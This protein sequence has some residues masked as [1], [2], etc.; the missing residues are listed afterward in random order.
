MRYRVPMPRKPAV[1]M[2]DD[3]ALSSMPDGPRNAVRYS[4][5]FAEDAHAKLGKEAIVFA[6]ERLS[7]TIIYENEAQI[8]R[9]VES[10]LFDREWAEPIIRRAIRESVARFIQDMMTNS[11]AFD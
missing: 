5:D 6:V 3:V 4:M 11:D 7:Q 9:T 8:R 2:A 10:F 1:I